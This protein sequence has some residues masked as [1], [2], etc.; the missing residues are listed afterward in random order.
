MCVSFQPLIIII[1]EK[2]TR[3][4]NLL[5]SRLNSSSNV[6]TLYFECIPHSLSDLNESIF[7]HFSNI[8]IRR[9]VGTHSFTI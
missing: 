8:N 7:N 9:D 5:D 4:Y 1:Q 3:S 6:N 2:Y